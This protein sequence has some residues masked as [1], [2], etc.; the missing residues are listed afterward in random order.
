MALPNPSPAEK[1]AINSGVAWLK[2]VAINDM[3]W[4][5]TPSGRDLVAAPG[6]GLIWARYYQI[7][8]DKP[9]FG[10]RDKSIH[11]KVTEISL[12]RRNGYAWYGIA[13]R[14]TLKQYDSWRA[15]H[16]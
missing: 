2:K 14:E 16:P 3:A 13:P 1:T 6:S 8:T 12:E 5:P 11:D 15:A 7:G 9:L 10:D 4:R